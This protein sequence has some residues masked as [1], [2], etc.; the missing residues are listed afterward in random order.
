MDQLAKSSLP[1]SVSISSELIQAS[2]VDNGSR[3][4]QSQGDSIDR[5]HPAGAALR[6]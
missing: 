6:G 1:A 3:A 5:I 2:V 4:E